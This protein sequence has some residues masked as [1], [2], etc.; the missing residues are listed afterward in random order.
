ATAQLDALAARIE[1]GSS[2]ARGDLDK[3]QLALGTVAT[4]EP[5]APETDL[6]ALRDRLSRLAEAAAAT[7]PGLAGTLQ[8]FAMQL[9][10]AMVE[11][12]SD[13]DLPVISNILRTL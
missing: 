4:A 5:P 9:S 6:A 7:D 2:P 11:P 3:L 10:P 12:A 1:A 8:A 13:P